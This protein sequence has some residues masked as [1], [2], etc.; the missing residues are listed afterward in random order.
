MGSTLHCHYLTALLETGKTRQAL[1][2]ANSVWLHGRSRPKA[3]DRILE[4]WIDAGEMTTE[5]AWQRVVLAMQASQGGLANYLKRFLNERQKGW[6]AAWRELQRHPEQI[7]Q[8]QPK[9]IDTPSLQRITLDA[10][11]RLT[12]RDSDL[13]LQIWPDLRER[14]EPA[15]R[16]QGERALLRGLIGSDHPQRLAQLDAFKP[17]A[18]D[19]SMHER[20]LPVALEEQDWPRLFKRIDQLPA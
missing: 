3:C 16:Y 15:A 13:A 18:G 11:T 17:A 14:L 19:T 5:L 8:P 4:T 9:L 12:R 6:L 2:Q 10:F 20:R 1:D 7:A